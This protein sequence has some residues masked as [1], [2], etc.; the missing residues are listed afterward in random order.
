[1]INN[2]CLVLRVSGIKKFHC[3][4]ICDKLVPSTPS[5]SEE[6]KS[7]AQLSLS[8]FPLYK[9]LENRRRLKIGHRPFFMGWTLKTLKINPHKPAS[10]QKDRNSPIIVERY[11]N[12]GYKDSTECQWEM[13]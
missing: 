3:T 1:M 5:I 8:L 12:R 9:P 7:P 11:E 13:C 10:S 2:V 4:T 6:S